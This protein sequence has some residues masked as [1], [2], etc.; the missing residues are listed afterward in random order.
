MSKP[1]VFIFAMDHAL[2]TAMAMHEDG[3]ILYQHSSDSYED[4]IQWLHHHHPNLR[5]DYE[6]ITPDKKLIKANLYEGANIST[7][8]ED[9]Q[10]AFTNN[11]EL[12]RKAK[13][14]ENI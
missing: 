13:E 7:L 8:G 5:K 1:K 2:P 10:K 4:A 14:K 6:C 12:G 9:I 3:R 11:Q